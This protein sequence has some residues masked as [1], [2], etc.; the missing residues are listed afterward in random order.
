MDPNII[1]NGA[2]PWNPEGPALSSRGTRQIRVLAVVKDGHKCF[3]FLLPL[4]MDTHV[5]LDFGFARQVTRLILSLQPDLA[6][7]ARL[8]TRPTLSLQ[9]DLAMAFS[10]ACVVFV[11]PF[12]GVFSRHV[13]PAE[14]MGVDS[15]MPCPLNADA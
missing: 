9:P 11:L 6:M 3:A 5:C 8:I 12:L 1:C 10:A 7:V 13:R 15:L 14:C 4:R 2:Q